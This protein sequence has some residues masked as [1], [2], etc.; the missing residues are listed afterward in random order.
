[1]YKH[2]KRQTDRQTDR[3]MKTLVQ[4]TNVISKRQAIVWLWVFSYFNFDVSN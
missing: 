3:G 4:F 2:T 1:M